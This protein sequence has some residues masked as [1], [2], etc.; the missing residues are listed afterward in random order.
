[1]VFKI[2]FACFIELDVH[3]QECVQILDGY[4]SDLRGYMKKFPWPDGG[5]TETPAC[6]HTPTTDAATEREW[7]SMSDEVSRTLYRHLFIET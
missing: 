2:K 4:I 5:T 7:Q 1:M 6:P 3:L